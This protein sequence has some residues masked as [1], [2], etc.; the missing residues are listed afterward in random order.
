MKKRTLKQWGL[1]LTGDGSKPK[2]WK[3]EDELLFDSEALEPRVLLSALAVD[4]TAIVQEDAVFDS[5]VDELNGGGDTSVEDND[6][7]VF[8]AGSPAENDVAPLSASIDGLKGA[9]G[10]AA[11][12]PSPIDFETDGTFTFDGTGSDVIQA[13]S[14][15]EVGNFDFEYHFVDLPIEAGTVGR[16]DLIVQGANDAFDVTFGDANYDYIVNGNAIEFD[17][18]LV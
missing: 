15:G 4:D 13:L 5:T 11:G 18:P 1:N 2:H 12:D 9:L 14:E 17:A 10:F 6:Q 16:V 3:I 7:N 8:G